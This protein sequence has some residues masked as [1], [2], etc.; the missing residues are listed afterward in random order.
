MAKAEAIPAFTE[1]ELRALT[2]FLNHLHEYKELEPR[3]RLTYV[4]PRGYAQ[5]LGRVRKKLEARRK[6]LIEPL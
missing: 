5:A 2:S 4:L 3:T 6:A 1:M